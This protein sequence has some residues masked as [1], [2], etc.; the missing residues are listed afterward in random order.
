MKNFNENRLGISGHLQVAK[1]Y[2]NGEEEV[3]HDDHN[4]I[5][6]GMSAGLAIMFAGV[7]STNILDYHLDRVQLGVSSTDP[8]SVKD[9]SATYS[10]SGPL[11]SVAEYGNDSKL[12]IAT[13]D[14]YQNGAFVSSPI[15]TD[16][17]GAAPFALIPHSK[18][19]KISDSS[20]RFTIVFDEDACN[21][22]QR[23]TNA[24]ALYSK[25]L[26]EIGLF[27]KNPHATVGQ[28]S[29]LCA[30]RQFSDIIKTSDFSLIFRWTINF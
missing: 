24:G 3:V 14:H 17:T 15:A 22:I 5:T 13:N 16:Q 8:T 19:T 29:V 11:S 25:P 10:L 6:S 9:T 23:Y 26:N 28:A 20:V 4:V 27:M 21:D 30:Y 12:F 18:T 1:L 7:G 2:K